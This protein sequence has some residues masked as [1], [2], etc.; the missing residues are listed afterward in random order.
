MTSDEG[1]FAVTCNGPNCDRETLMEPGAPGPHGW[2]DLSTWDDATNTATSLGYF[3]SVA[4]L[5]EAVPSL[6]E[7]HGGE[8]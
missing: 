2:L 5:E 4:C 3:C 1:G 8:R 7:L 6:P